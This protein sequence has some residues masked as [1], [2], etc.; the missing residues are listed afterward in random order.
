MLA[1]YATDTAPLYGEIK[2]SSPDWH[3]ATFTDRG[4][5]HVTSGP[6][7][8]RTLEDWYSQPAP[9]ERRLVRYVVRLGALRPPRPECDISLACTRHGAQ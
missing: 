6:S 1:P 4:R 3:K 5:T 9:A 2:G 8:L 7:E